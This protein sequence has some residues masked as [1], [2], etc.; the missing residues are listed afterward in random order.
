IPFATFLGFNGEKVPDI[1]LNFSGDF[2]PRA[3]EFC[4]TIFGVD[5]AFRAGTIGTIA[6]KTAIGHVKN[7]CERKGIQMRRAEMLNF[8]HKIMGVKR[9]TGQHP[10]GIVVIPKEIEYCDITPIQYPADDVTSSWRT[11][12]FDY[13]KFESNLLKLDILG[14]DDP[15]MIR[16]LMNFVEAYPDEFKFSTVEGIPLTDK[17]VFGLFNGLESLGLTPSQTFGQTIG[18]TGIPEFGTTLTKKM[19][20][21][22]RPDS[23][24]SLLKISGLSHGKGV[25]QGNSQDFMMGKKTGF[26]TI[27]FDDLIGCR[28]D[29]ML[30]LIDKHLPSIDAF[31]IME[32][33]RHGRGLTPAME[34]EMVEYNVPEWYI[35]SCKMIQY[36]FPKA[37]ATAYVIMALRIGWFKVHKPIYYYA[38][39]FSRR[40]D[41]YDVESMA[42]GAEAI[43]AKLLELQEK[44]DNKTALPKDGDIFN[45][46]LLAIEM[47][48]RGYRF[49]QIDINKSAARDFLVTKDKMGLI[50]PFSALEGLGETIGK[51][52]VEARS[53]APFTSKEDVR[54]RTKIN[55]TQ[56]EKMNSLGSF[57]DLPEKDQMGLF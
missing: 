36:M 30:Y 15:T 56:F 16:H 28:D 26:A 19:L 29:I 34:K 37:H 55:N 41:G 40:A 54:K 11:T 4:R 18:T 38:A 2:Q 53:Q 23:V 45:A 42:D 44:L 17:K 35:Q 20:M 21:Q 27:D 33:V 49:L 51:T 5:R 8:A 1:D 13:H 46:L 43:Q 50:I 47:V 25:W 6:E 24:A 3:H 7:Y 32:K 39:Y 22:I 31:A 57:K 10:G 9:S 48:S 12:H 14:H 52:I